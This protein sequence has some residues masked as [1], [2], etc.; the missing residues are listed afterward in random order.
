MFLL[1][2]LFLSFS[3]LSNSQNIKLEIIGNYMLIDNNGKFYDC[4]LHDLIVTKISKDS[5]EYWIK[6]RHTKEYYVEKGLFVNFKQSDGSNFNSLSDLDNFL[7]KNTAVFNSLSESNGSSP[8]TAEQ[9]QEI[10]DSNRKSEREPTFSASANQTT[11]T[12]SEKANDVEIWVN[13][14]IQHTGLDFDHVEDQITFV[15]GLELG[16]IVSIRKF[17]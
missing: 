10:N 7:Y 5:D 3:N 12:L 15:G 4:I 17:F 14:V 2:V 8:V 6:D 1:F 13:N 16:D 9:I 11:Y